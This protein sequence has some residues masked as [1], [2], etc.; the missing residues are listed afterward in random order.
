LRYGP[1]QIVH[2]A[3]RSTYSASP[4]NL[5]TV[6]VAVIFSLLDSDAASSSEW[7]FAK[8]KS[9]GRFPH[10]EKICATMPDCSSFQI[11][12]YSGNGATQKRALSAT[13]KGIPFNRSET[14][15]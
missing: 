8:R 6:L 11:F 1:A 9:C 4:I 10:N 2:R 7:L 5:C 15:F 3:A 12:F 14:E 13:D